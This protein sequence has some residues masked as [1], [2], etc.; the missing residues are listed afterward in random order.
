MATR[1][2]TRTGDEGETGLIGGVRVRKDSPII[3]LVGELDELN[4]VLGLARSAP[5]SPLIED[6]LSRAQ[7]LLL[8]M[9][10]EI[11]SPR[12]SPYFLEAKVEVEPQRLEAAID[13]M[14]SQLPPLKQF[15]LPGGCE[16]SSR[17]H[18]ARSICRRAERS[19]VSV[20]VRAELLV[21]VNRLSDFLFV[22]ARMANS[23]ANVPDVPWSRTS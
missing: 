15:I 10:A 19:M 1:I 16:S 9:G 18:L 6:A 23:E 2:Y 17:L 4:A 8:D 14:E 11:A 20:G 5:L 7:S 13:E 22:A 12:D 3:S 21:Y